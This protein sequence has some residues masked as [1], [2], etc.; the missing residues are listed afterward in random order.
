MRVA[1]NLTNGLVR[2]QRLQKVVEV[3]QIGKRSRTAKV[4]WKGERQ[5]LG[6]ALDVISELLGS[7]HSTVQGAVS[8]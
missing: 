7:H 2:L 5:L 1:Y 8:K 3:A 6:T 4:E